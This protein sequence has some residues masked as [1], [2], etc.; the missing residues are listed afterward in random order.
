MGG[1]SG[2]DLASRGLA[3]TRGTTVVIQGAAFKH[4]FERRVDWRRTKIFEHLFVSGLDLF[5]HLLYGRT[6]VRSNT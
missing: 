6:H 3:V 5:E 1:A 2:P 4:L